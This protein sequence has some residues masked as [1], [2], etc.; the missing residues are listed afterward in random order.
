MF[1]RE[2]FR[3]I[4]DWLPQVVADGDDQVGRANMAQAALYA[5]IAVA[6]AGAG[7]VHALAYPLGGKISLPHGFANGMLL[8]HVLRRN[9][10][11]CP[12]AYAGIGAIVSQIG[13]RSR[14]D[15]V[16]QV[17][18]EMLQKLDAPTKLSE[19]GVERTA[20]PGLAAQASEIRRLLDNNVREFG[21]Q[22]ILAIYEAAW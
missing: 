1:S 19:Y 10:D 21:Q 8:P 17:V 5:G 7:A 22:E 12:A 2:A 14:R 18:G 20:L 4:V 15:D 11:V 9:V 3:L 13:A 6:N 16:V